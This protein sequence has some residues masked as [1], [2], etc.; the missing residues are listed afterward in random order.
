MKI[1][2]NVIQC[3]QKELHT[4]S[5]SSNS[6]NNNNL[7]KEGASAPAAA[8]AAPAVPWHISLPDR[9]VALITISFYGHN[10]GWEGGAWRANQICLICYCVL[11]IQPPLPQS[12][13]P[14]KKK[15]AFH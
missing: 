10:N 11:G 7:S 6:N 4:G 5:N 9:Q 2:I 12:S 3:Q 1:T 8:P 15:N 14:F 13:A